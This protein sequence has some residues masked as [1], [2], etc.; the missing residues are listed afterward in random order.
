MNFEDYMAAKKGFK[1]NKNITKFLQ[2]RLGINNNTAEIIAVAYDLQAGTYNDFADKNLD[3]F[4]KRTKE[5]VEFIESNVQD[6]KSILDI[7]TGELTMFSRVMSKLSSPSNINFYAIDISLSR[8]I[9]GRDDF[10]KTINSDLNL[11]LAVADSAKLPFASKSIEIITTDHSLEPNGG[12]LEEL[13]KECFRVAKRFCV[14]IE[15]SIKIQS[16]AGVE[17]MKSLGYICDLDETIEKLGGKVVAEY[18]TKNN[19]NSL[20]KSKMILVKVPSL[21]SEELSDNNDLNNFTYPGEDYLLEEK[22]GFLYNK[23]S[24]FAFPIIDGIP[25]LVEQNRILYTQFN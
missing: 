21:S 1:K 24:G 4:E 18:L 6:I 5:V 13:I 25:I 22:N 3:L 23:E 10:Y 11:K 14:F 17:R 15:P 9:V 20:N 12:R 16:E 2:N 8:L 19:Y 7:G